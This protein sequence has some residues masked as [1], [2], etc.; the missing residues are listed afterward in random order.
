MLSMKA[1]KILALLANND[2]LPL[3]IKQIAAALEMSERSVGT[4]LKEVY[5]YCREQQLKVV[6]KPGV[7]ILL[8]TGNRREELLTKLSGETPFYSSEYRVHYIISLLLNNWTTYTISLFADDLS[9]SKTTVEAD[10]K[11]AERWFDGFDIKVLKKTGSG[12]CL[13]GAELDIRRAI[14][15]INRIFYTPQA[16]PLDRP[17]DYRL[18]DETLH[19][20]TGAYRNCNIGYYTELI[21]RMDRYSRRPLTD[22]GFESMLEYLIVAQQRIKLGCYM[23]ENFWPN[24]PN[25]R[26]NIDVSVKILADAL[27][28]PKAEQDY[29]ELLLCC[30]E[31]QYSEKRQEELYQNPRP[32]LL[33]FTNELIAYISGVVGLDFTHDLLFH[34]V[35]YYFVRSSLLRVQYGIELLNPFLEDVKKTYPAIFYACFAAGTIYQ[36]WVGRYPSENEISSLS[37]LVGGAVIRSDKKI[38]AVVVCA[39]GI[40]TAQI[41]ARKIED[42]QQQIRVSDILSFN[43][44]DR[45][46]NIRPQLVITTLPSLRTTYPMVVIS[47][48]LSERDLQKLSRACAEVYTKAAA[49]KESALLQL[50]KDELIFLDQELSKERALRLMAGQMERQGYVREGFYQD[51][52]SREQIGST[53]LGKG[54]AI[55][56][57]VSGLVRE[58]A[59]GLLR[60]PRSVD[61]GGEPVDLIFVLALNFSDI[62]NTKAFFQAFY[63]MTS[64]LETVDLIRRAGTKEE[65]RRIIA[66]RCI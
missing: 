35:V 36:Q 61:W 3:T 23:P 56:H 46:E 12:I 10:L 19:R 53:A 40:G 30:T 64:D 42:L 24:K 32:E 52:L 1:S 57:G 50:L 17:R 34:K 20:L 15:A 59:I 60:L 54:V 18:S 29:V 49:P 13:S 37:L 2:P 48:V 39:A 25:D 31:W 66:E 47:P 28:L 45:L 44:L 26:I 63:K 21:Q 27:D 4:Y 65:L 55:P 62:E 14:A 43:E 5:A 16:K 58:P 38:H 22:I 7:G 41:V 33:R 6:N 11:E 8:K 51:L 9:V